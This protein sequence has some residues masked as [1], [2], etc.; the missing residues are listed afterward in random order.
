MERVSLTDQP[1]GPDA[2]EQILD[3]A[4]QEAS[5]ETVQQETQQEEEA[6][7][8]P[9]WLRDKFSSA[10]ELAKAYDN[11]EKKMSSRQAEEKGLLTEADFDEY[12]AE[13]NENGGLSDAT[14]DALA[15]KGLS[16][17]LVDNY[18]A[19]QT[20]RAEQEADELFNLA[21]GEESYKGMTEWMSENLSED[22]VETFNDAIDASTDMAAMA[23]RGMYAQY[24]AAVGGTAEPRLLQG[25]KAEAQGGYSSTYEMK[26]DMKD[27]RYK[28]GD[29]AFHNYVERRL[30]ASGNLI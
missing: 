27:P 8:R 3:E 23:I 21:G 24:T 20:V 26:Q 28:A 6:T 16:R 13:Y 25:G 12:T 19:G 5:E 15:K 29:P 9:S 22:E 10:E 14:Y 7:E 30:A 2:P 18:I 1:T 17:D 4:L 11:L